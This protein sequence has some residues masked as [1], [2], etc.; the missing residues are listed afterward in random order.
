MVS[1]LLSDWRASGD[2]A[3]ESSNI[4]A[5]R[6]DPGSGFPIHKADTDTDP[7]DVLLRVGG[8]I[9]QHLDRHLSHYGPF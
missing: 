4:H 1:R 8:T 2:L 5:L 6:I 9:D 3:S 7:G